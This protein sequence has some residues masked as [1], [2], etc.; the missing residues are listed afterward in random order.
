MLKKFLGFVN[1]TGDVAV[2]KKRTKQD[3]MAVENSGISIDSLPP[4][5]IDAMNSPFI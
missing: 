5:A 2:I 4:E 1:A 3:D